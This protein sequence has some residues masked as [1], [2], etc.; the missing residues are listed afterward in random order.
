MVNGIEEPLISIIEL[1][2]LKAFETIILTT[3]M[4]PLRT[5]LTPDYK[6]NWGYEI[7]PA[8]I[9]QRKNE[10]IHIYEF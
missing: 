4:L 10:E 5:K 1:K 9:P 2:T 8:E 3:R 7:E 6:I